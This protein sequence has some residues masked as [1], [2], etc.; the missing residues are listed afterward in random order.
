MRPCRLAL[1]IVLALPALGLALDVPLGGHKIALRASAS[2]ARKRSA[3][4]TIKDAALTAP[5]PDPT[6]GASLVV[7]GG[8]ADGQ[9]HVEI[10]LDPSAWRPLGGDGPTRGYRYTVPAPGTQGVRKIVLRPGLLIVKAR[11][12]SWPCDLGAA[13]QREPV[14]VVLR[15]AGARYCAAFGPATRNSSGRFVAGASPAPAACPETDA[16]GAF[17]NI[18]HGIFCPA[19]TAGCR[20]AERIDLLFQW[21]A[22][23]GCPDVV[24]LTEVNDPS[25][26]L[27]DSHLASTCPF[28]YQKVFVRRFGVD[29][30]MLLTRYPAAAFESQLLYKNFRHVL[31][32]R[33]DHPLGPLD[34]FTTHLASGSDGASNPC[35]GDCPAECIAAGATTVREC[36]GVQIGD[37]VALRHDVATPALVSGDFNVE[38]AS[39]VYTHLLGRGFTDTHLVAGNPECNP[40]TGVGCTSGRDD[41]S[42]TDLESPASN[43]DRRID[44]FFLVPPGPGSL[45]TAAIDSGSDAD[46]DGTATRIFADDPNPFAP[47][48]GPAPDAICWPSDHEG[49][50]VDLNCG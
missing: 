21:V 46:G 8:A 42:L 14:S 16:T 37:Q 33:I 20:L 26:P 1:G 4:I 9:C 47:T 44:F 45:C 27:I 15:I 49:A 38:P 29:D 32:V 7:N 10:T 13:S 35:A 48:C 34:V 17:L 3:S 22:A 18:L 39:F 43:V 28:T 25:V 36:Q 2:V 12:A 31:F 50:Q 6:L 11:G 5:L 23:A 30:H 40:G 41:E 19:P 24:T